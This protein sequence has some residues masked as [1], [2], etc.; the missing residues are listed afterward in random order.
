V[1]KIILKGYLTFTQG[2]VETMPSI[3]ALT[4]LVILGLMIALWLVS[5]LLKDSS[6][7]DIFWGAGFVIIAWVYFFLTPDGHAAR[8]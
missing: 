7:V 2:R 6:I 8:K 3:Y 5:L 4:G 1:G